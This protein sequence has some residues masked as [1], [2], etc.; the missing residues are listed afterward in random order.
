M[1]LEVGQLYI[2]PKEHTWTKVPQF[3]FEKPSLYLG[4]DE[5]K[6]SDGKIIINHAFLVG[7]DRRLFDQSLAH[8][9]RLINE[10]R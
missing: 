9:M 4:P 3:V 8:K 7:G 2:L 5:C 1:S 10:G 6:T